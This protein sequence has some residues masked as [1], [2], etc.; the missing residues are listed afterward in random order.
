MARKSE[1]GSRFAATSIIWGFATVML[2]ICIPLV[3]NNGS[4]TI[5]PLAVILGASVSTVAVC[6]GSDNQSRNS[7]LLT[8]SIK[9]LEHRMSNLEIICS[10]QELDLQSKIKQLESRD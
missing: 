7:P 4:A 9:E 2:A 8:N 5:L 6:R 1:K 3:Q 10:S